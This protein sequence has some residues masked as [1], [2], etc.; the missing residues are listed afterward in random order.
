MRNGKSV[1]WWML[2]IYLIFSVSS[3]A[4]AQAV[5]SETDTASDDS[6]VDT[7]S[8]DSALPQGQMMT[9][10]D[11]IRELEIRL[12]AHIDQRYSEGKKESAT[13]QEIENEIRAHTDQ[14]YSELNTEISALG[15]VVDR[16]RAHIDQ[17]YSELNTEI[18]AIGEIRLRDHIN[19][20]HS[21]H[22]AKIGELGEDVEKLTEEAHILKIWL[23]VVFTFLVLI[24]IPALQWWRNTSVVKR[25]LR[26]IMHFLNQSKPPDA[27][28]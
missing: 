1:L 6:G 26:R 7:V 10:M 9:I 24:V 2:G 8:D 25:V 19:A 28:I 16:L 5:P 27:S 20:K 4:L 21:E 18:S 15:G 23:F 22:N 12:R 3:G 17:R 14:R 13:L 11:E